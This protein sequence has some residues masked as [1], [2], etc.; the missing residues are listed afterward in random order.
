MLFIFVDNNSTQTVQEKIF[1][2]LPKESALHRLF[3]SN[4]E[5]T[6]MIQSKY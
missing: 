6:K 2:L 3:T 4:L 5:V 1:Y